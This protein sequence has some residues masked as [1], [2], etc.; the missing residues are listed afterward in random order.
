MPV[1]Q[2]RNHAPSL[3]RAVVQH[4]RARVGHAA[5]APC[6]HA[7]SLLDLVNG[8]FVIESAFESFDLPRGLDIPLGRNSGRRNKLTFA[9]SR[10][11][12]CNRCSKPIRLAFHYFRIV[13]PQTLNEPLVTGADRHVAPPHIVARNLR[14]PFHSRS[15]GIPRCGPARSNTNG[16]EYPLA[17]IG[18]GAHRVSLRLAVFR[19]AHH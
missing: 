10:N 4:N 8:Q 6:Q 1:R 13:F 11:L 2:Q 14:I 19:S 17:A 5:K 15:R 9:A 12:R 18:H 3:G 7:L 16:F